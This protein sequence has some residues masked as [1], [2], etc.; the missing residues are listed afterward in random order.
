MPDHLSDPDASRYPW[1]L[2]VSSPGNG[3]EPTAGRP[4]PFGYGYPVCAA[5][6]TIRHGNGP[7]YEMIL[8]ERARTHGTVHDDHH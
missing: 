2:T 5:G 1:F 3:P 7:L 4:C 6:K 8:E